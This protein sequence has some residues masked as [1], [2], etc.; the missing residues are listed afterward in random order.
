MR[1]A[2]RLLGVL[3]A[4]LLLTVACGRPN[5]VGAWSGQDPNDHNNPV[6]LVISTEQGN[7]LTGSLNELSLRTGSI[8]SVTVEGTVHGKKISLA[9]NSGGT[10][11][12]AIPLTYYGRSITIEVQGKGA[13]PITLTY[14]NGSYATLAAMAQGS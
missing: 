8:S 3:A 14:G 11:S 9:I 13:Q 6:E 10:K 2:R 4:T 1:H 5:L 12:P 7:H